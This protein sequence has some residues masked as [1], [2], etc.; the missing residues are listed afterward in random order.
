VD[1]YGH[2]FDRGQ[3]CGSICH[4]QGRKFRQADTSFLHLLESRDNGE[5]WSAPRE[6]N[7]Q[8]KADWMKFIGAGP[9]TGLQL[10]DGPHRGRLIYPIYFSSAFSDAYSAGAIY[11]DDHGLTWHRGASVNDGRV[12]EGKVLAARDADD[13]R[14]TLGECQI[15]ELPGGRLRIFLRNPL[16]HHTAAAYSDD[17]G[18]SWYG[19]AHQAELPDPECQSHVLRVTYRGQDRYLFSNPAHET[20]RVRGT[21]RLSADG[22]EHW[23]AQRLVEPGEFAYSCMTQL[24]DGQIGLLYE[25]A[26][27]TP[28]FVKFPLEWVLEGAAADSAVVPAERLERI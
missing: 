17:G 28:R 23:S 14:A 18:Q 19:L 12:F 9:G 16:A 24:P 25:G 10:R 27:L 6:L 5:T 26:D 1:A 15:T 7:P 2:L 4:G 22:T 3:P 8:V 21:V 20:A 13:P 11:S